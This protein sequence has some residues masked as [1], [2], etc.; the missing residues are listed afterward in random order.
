MLKKRALVILSCLFLVVTFF[1]IFKN[2]R[3]EG[4]Q[5][6][7]HYYHLRL[8]QIIAE[9]DILPMELPQIED[10]GWGKA[11]REKEF[12]FHQLSGLAY[13]IH[14]EAGVEALVPVIYGGL[15]LVLILTCIQLFGVSLPLAIFSS[16]SA[17]ATSIYFVQRANLLRPHSLAIVIFLWITYFYVRILTKPE[18]NK[19]NLIALF[20][21]YVIFCL[22]YHA[23]YLPLMMGVI[24][25]IF[26]PSKVNKPKFAFYLGLSTLIGMIINP[27]FPGN[28]EISLRALTIA[29]ND[30]SSS[31]L[32]FGNELIP[33]R[34][35]FFL[36]TYGQFF[37]LLVCSAYFFTTSRS[38]KAIFNF[39][40]LTSA[41]FWAL[42]FISPR[43][44]EYGI[45]LS[46]LLL[47]YSLKES[48]G[49]LQKAFLIL[50]FFALPIAFQHASL[51][52]F[53]QHKTHETPEHVQ[54]VF[55]ALA[56]L[57]SNSNGKKVYNLEW[58]M[59]PY[60]FYKRPDLR[61]IDI[62]DPSILLA[63]SP[64]L[65]HARVSLTS[66]KEPDAYGLIK[67]AGEA[68]YVLTRDL[69]TAQQLES[70]P[71]FL[72]LYPDPKPSHLDES[73]LVYLF[74]LNPR[75]RQNFMK[76]FVHRI[77]FDYEKLEPNMREDY[78]KLTPES[79][80]TLSPTLL[81]PG[82]DAAV[83]PVYLDYEKVIKAKLQKEVDPKKAKIPFCA[84][85]TTQAN[86]L[87]NG[88]TVLG[89]GGGRNVRLWINHHTIYS[90]V[91]PT[92]EP[93]LIRDLIEL[94]KPLKSGDLIEI[95][96]C[97]TLD[98]AF[99]GFSLSS[100]TKTELI[101]VCATKNYHEPTPFKDQKPWKYYGAQKDTNC[102]A[103]FQ[104]LK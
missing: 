59:T 50:P 17:T 94:E 60:V 30:V 51:A 19:R 55:K 71:M 21:L 52:T 102:L 15:F 97:G 48:S 10:I 63:H 92:S 88:N 96:T 35:D 65:H 26:I 40:F 64:T 4:L 14:G 101:E 22:S 90:S 41:M 31:N 75:Y 73:A 38:N 82:L 93:K 27:Y 98:A 54:A 70:D 91:I 85:A 103:H 56:T 87:Q 45:P 32:N 5:D 12:L 23:F 78:L 80:A 1:F 53:Y 16:L 84:L 81:N 58:D 77:G 100:W 2:Y 42:T 37:A 3:F 18:D 7:D 43:A 76:D 86:S 89:I 29:T 46:A 57:P 83:S 61:F 66:G 47:C 34:S 72:R 13:R 49:L 95:L 62:L 104:T 8:S 25:L 69:R 20:S 44:S 68:D 6:P 24:F 11:F 67:F 28:V 36:K 9:K 74:E 99:F 39:L 79:L 33:V